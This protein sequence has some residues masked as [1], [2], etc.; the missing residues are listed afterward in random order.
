VCFSGGVDSTFL[1]KIAVDELGPGQAMGLLEHG[2]LYPESATSEA[3]QLAGIIGAQLEEVEMEPL[4]GSEVESN[5]T[6]RCYHCKSGL[7]KHARDVAD[8]LGIRHVAEGTNADDADDYRPGMGAVKELGVQSPLLE[9]GLTKDEIRAAS[10]ELG[11]PTWDRPAS[12]C[13]ASRFPFGTRIDP[14]RIDM[15]N[16]SEKALSEAGF[17]EFRVRYHGDVAR[18]ELAAEEIPK[19]FEGNRYVGIARACREA[20][21]RYVALDLDGYRTGSLNPASYPGKKLV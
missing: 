21:F 17:R 2:L 19:M 15:V 20:G 11:L 18:I 13:L 14:E 16:R 8:R 7:L 3:R 4:E 12:P 9:A 6:D 5:P 10:R 1:L